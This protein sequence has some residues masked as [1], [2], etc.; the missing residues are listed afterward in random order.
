ME[1][2]RRNLAAEE[3]RPQGLRSAAVSV[4]FRVTESPSI[5]L[6]KRAERSGDPWSG[7][8]AFPGGKAQPGDRNARDTAVRETLEE[9][10]FD[11]NKAAEFL[12]Y[13]APATTHTGTMEVVPLVFELREAVEVRPNEEVSS[14]HWVRMEELLAA[15]AQST[16]RRQFAGNRVEL[17]AYAV[18]DY[19]VW[20]LT[21]RILS[22][23]V[24]G[25]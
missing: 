15:A 12:G 3:P 14:Y 19:V 24:R 6:I 4:I 16:Y 21:H 7:H 23:L 9:V 8:I 22:S 18:G 10:G 20:G 5:L 2:V 11:L 1:G 13:G 25:V 17:P